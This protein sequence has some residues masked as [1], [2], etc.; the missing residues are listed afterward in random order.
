LD[1]V[2]P[3]TVDELAASLSVPLSKIEQALARLEGEGFAMQGKFTPHGY[4]GVPACNSEEQPAETRAY[5]EWCSR[6]L[7]ARIHSYTLNRLRKEIEPVSAADFLR[8][9][10]VWQKV[11]PDHHVEG[12][13]SV[14]AILDQLEGF[15]APAGAWESETLPARL[16]DSRRA[17]VDRRCLPGRLRGLALAP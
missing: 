10:V 13:E 7:L 11:A 14:A 5:P 4:A 2:G 15:G 3:T 6:R 12:P 1:G 8:F 9:V 17:C 16:P